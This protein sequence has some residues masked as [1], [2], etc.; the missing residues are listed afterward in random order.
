[1]APK[2][3]DLKFD[4]AIARH[5]RA[6]AGAEA[7]DLRATSVPCPNPEVLAAYHERSLPPEEMSSWKQHIVDCADCQSILAHLEMT[8][9]LPL[10]AADI[11]VPAV[12][13][14][15]PSVSERPGE[16]RRK[17]AILHGT[18]WKW[19]APAGALAASLLLWVAWH[20]ESKPAATKS[21]SVE[22]AKVQEPTAPLQEEYRAVIP[23][24]PR[25]PESKPGSIS[26]GV[27]SVPRPARRDELA[28]TPLEKDVSN[29]RSKS[30]SPEVRINKKS[31]KQG[32]AYA[33]DIGAAS[34]TVEV[35]TAESA[36]FDSGPAGLKKEGEVR[37]QL[38][39]DQSQNLNQMAANAPKAVGPAPPS[40]V[41]PAKAL[42]A[43]S[44]AAAPPPAP[45]TAGYLDQRTAGV[46]E[47]VSNS[48]P[49]VILSADGTKSWRA[50]QGGIIESSSDDRKTWTR[51]FSGVLTD[52]LTGTA[53]SATT[54]WIVGR[55]GT[56]IVTTDGGA[57]WK[58]VK[59]PITGDLGGVRATDALHATI[60]DSR[61]TQYFQTGNGGQ[62]WQSTTAP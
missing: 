5:F 1:M 46:L 30:V 10:D 39:N 26:G 48:D 62:T 42:K 36:K 61:N 3:R 47:V 37:N 50:G 29:T 11:H 20:E 2:D 45:A 21:G 33:G 57:H 31:D 12:G 23:P 4:K 6:G 34:Q 16:G 59:T 58:L 22:M 38:S 35:Q 17:I 41:T 7:P 56:L 53:P 24:P 49:R 27:A 9:D 43:K 28:L 8:D 60:W 25:D 14:M 15:V 32:T 40:Q 55:S 44:T 18:R 54:C 19:L 13:G 52:L 51:Q